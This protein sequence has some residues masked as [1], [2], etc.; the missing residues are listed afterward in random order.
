MTT[1]DTTTEDSPRSIS[2]GEF[3]DRLDAGTGEFRA[4]H[5]AWALMIGYVQP[6]DAWP[7]IFANDMDALEDLIH[8]DKDEDMGVEFEPAPEHGPEQHVPGYCVC[9]ELLH[10]VRS[11]S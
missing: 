6:A 5:L 3:Q 9:G 7:A 1:T 4:A 2:H 10:D 11:T 8:D